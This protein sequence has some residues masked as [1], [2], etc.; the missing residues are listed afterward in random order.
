MFNG[1]ASL[2][3]CSDLLDMGAIPFAVGGTLF[4][5]WNPKNGVPDFNHRIIATANRCRP[6]L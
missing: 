5:D 2:P 3:I 4:A 1:N 6:D